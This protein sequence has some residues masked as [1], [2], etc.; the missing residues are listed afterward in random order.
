MQCTYVAGWHCFQNTPFLKANRSALGH[1]VGFIPDFLERLSLMIG[2]DYEIR[3]V[4]DGMYG[5]RK[6][7]GYWN[8]MIGELIGGVRYVCIIILWIQLS[9][10]YYF[11][12]YLDCL[13]EGLVGGV[14]CTVVEHWS[15]TGELSLSCAW[16]LAGRM[17]TLWVRRPL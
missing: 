16:L 10:F 14:E 11:M 12:T 4:R 5:S 6:Q 13:W 2:F 9:T 17:I 3:L 15:L 1:Y 7:D 8:G